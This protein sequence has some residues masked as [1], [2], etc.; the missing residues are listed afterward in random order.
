MVLAGR[1]RPYSP[2]GRH[3]LLLPAVCWYGCAKGMLLNLGVMR[4]GLARC[5]PCRYTSLTEVQVGRQ[6]SMHASH[7]CQGAVLREG[8][9]SLVVAAGALPGRYHGPC[10]P[11]PCC[12]A[13]Q[14]QRRPAWIVPVGP[15][16]APPSRRCQRQGS[17][18]LLPVWRGAL[19]WCD[20]L[21]ACSYRGAAEPRSAPPRP[22]VKPNPKNAKD[23]AVAVQHEGERVLR[24]LQ[25]ADRVVLLDE[26]GR[27]VSSEDLARLLAQV[28][29][30]A[31]R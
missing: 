4:A 18:L 22:Q 17:R 12:K 14:G 20:P 26:R 10:K 19:V 8:L 16:E 11:W 9:K 30:R 2:A 21:A 5:L 1:H 29:R 13:D 25:P 23:T 3:A 27:D 15:A 7:S 31:L 24:A 6:R 28:G